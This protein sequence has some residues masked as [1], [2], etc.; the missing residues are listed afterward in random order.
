MPAE[1]I[2]QI[3]RR[4][5]LKI[6]GAA[7][8][9]GVVAETGLTQIFAINN[10]SPILPPT[11]EE[12]LAGG[13][14]CTG[15]NQCPENWYLGKDPACGKD[16][17]SC[18]DHPNQYTID[19]AQAVSPASSSES[20]ENPGDFE[21]IAQVMGGAKV[22]YVK[23]WS[24]IPGNYARDGKNPKFIDGLVHLRGFRDRW[25]GYNHPSPFGDSGYPKEGQWA[26]VFK[27]FTSQT[28]FKSVYIWAPN[29]PNKRLLSW[30]FYD[31]ETTDQKHPGQ[32]NFEWVRLERSNLQRIN[33]V[34]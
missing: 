21:Y 32:H 7:A 29:D 9:T 4:G 17:Y 27:L 25:N 1:Q 30:A 28:E 16:L 12:L 18:T 31:L 23:G 15:P 3:S 22:L 8:L 33:R 24:Y 11:A 14:W 13:P 5:F 20:A 26:G 6:A 10:N 19:R 2:K 34:R